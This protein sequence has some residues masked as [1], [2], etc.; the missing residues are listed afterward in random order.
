[1]EDVQISF[2]ERVKVLEFCLGGNGKSGL[3]GE[4][5]QDQEVEED[6]D[7]ERRQKEE[8]K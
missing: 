7:E 3:E 6:E 8:K 4:W 5:V 1:M 2:C